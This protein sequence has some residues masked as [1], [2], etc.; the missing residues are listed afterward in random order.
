MK[1]LDAAS[2]LTDVRRTSP[3]IQCMTNSVVMNFTA[4]AL[5]A[6]GAA[7]AMTDIPGE[8]GAFTRIASGL[9][10]NLGTP[11]A[12]RRQAMLESAPVAAEAAVPWVLDPVAVGNLPVRTRLADELLAHR[13]TAIRA[14]ASE[15][16]ALAGSGAGGRGVDAVDSA[17]DALDAAHTLAGRYGSIV[18]VS[19]ET[20]IITDGVTDIRVSNGHELLTSITGGGCVLGALTAAFVAC[21][22]SN[23]L[24]A[25]AAATA[26][27][28]VA[29][30]VAA[31]GAAGPG[32]FAVN[33]LDTLSGLNPTTI[34][35]RARI[36]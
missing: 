12:E 16:I 2:R 32:S 33:L 29:A 5:L 20:D 24:H 27:Y 9:L 26:V 36:T 21:E 7:P 31:E 14:N 3:L 1:A 4:N 25:V 22:R 17:A 35:T 15:I 6:I 34:E 28:T 11:Y 19:G 30:E 18:A 10:I 23:T 8:A 13:P